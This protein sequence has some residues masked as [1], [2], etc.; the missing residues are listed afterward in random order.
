MIAA[1]PAPPV[2]VIPQAGDRLVEGLVAV[3]QGWMAAPRGPA[4]GME[5]MVVPIRPGVDRVMASSEGGHHLGTVP[6]A[7]VPEMDQDPPAGVTAGMV[8]GA[9]IHAVQRIAARVTVVLKTAVLKIVAL[10]IGVSVQGDLKTAAREIAVMA[11]SASR[12][13]ALMTGVLLT[14]VQELGASVMARIAASVPAVASAGTVRLMASPAEKQLP[15]G[16][17][18]WLMICFGAGTPPRR[19]W[20]PVVRS[21]ASGAPARCAVLPNSCSFSGMPR[22]LEFLWRRSL[23]HVWLK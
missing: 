19:H 21:I 16:L 4:A 2:V 20:R 1:P 7:A 22:P 10:M 12:G 6:F 5:M 13:I 8:S 3:A 11:I 18:L 9:L 23:G 15:T 17:I 14:V